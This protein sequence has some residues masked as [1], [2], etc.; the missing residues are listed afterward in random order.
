VIKMLLFKIKKLL[1][2]FPNL[3]KMALSALK[4]FKDGRFVKKV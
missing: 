4:A 1:Y 2:S 3:V